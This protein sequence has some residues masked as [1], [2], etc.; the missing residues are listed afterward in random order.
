MGL[1]TE[2]TSNFKKGSLTNNPLVSIIWVNYN[3]SR[4]MNV[5]K[6]S[7]SSIKKLNYSNYELIIV[8]NASTDG[9]FE[10]I[11]S[12]LNEIGLK[13]KLIRT[14]RNLGFTG[15]NNIGYLM[16]NTNSKYIVMLNNDEVVYHDS[17]TK[18]IQAM[19]KDPK[20][21]ALQGVILWLGKDEINPC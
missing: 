18:M 15:G 19:K 16:R 2:I 6:M 7:L 14:K 1:T 20:C 11:K 5:V 10:Q 21:G 3:S 9:S 13:A 17:L 4:I 8:D 12:Y